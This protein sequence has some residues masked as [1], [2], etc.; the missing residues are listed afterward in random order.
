MWQSCTMTKFPLHK[1]WW[2]FYWKTPDL[3]Q[4]LFLGHITCCLWFVGGCA[5]DS[6]VCSFQDPGWK[7]YHSWGYVILMTRRRKRELR[8]NVECSFRN[9]GWVF[10][11]NNTITSIWQLAVSNL[12]CLTNICW[13]KVKM[14]ELKKC[15]EGAFLYETNYSFLFAPRVTF[16][17]LCFN[18][19]CL[20]TCQFHS[21]EFTSWRNNLVLYIFV[22]SFQ[23]LVIHSFI[24]KSSN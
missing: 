21:L 10:G 24:P 18:H 8:R 22:P 5:P 20:S 11:N 14:S 23:N 13:G 3:Y 15:Y 12:Q 16:K 2:D 7:G 4:S 9:R 17:Y 1:R 19:D 6:H